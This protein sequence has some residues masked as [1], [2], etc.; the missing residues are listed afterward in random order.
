MQKF[1][2]FSQVYAPGPDSRVVCCFKHGL[3]AGYVSEGPDCVGDR[4]KTKHVGSIWQNRCSD[5]TNFL[6]ECSLWSHIGI[7]ELCDYVRA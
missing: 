7:V 3:S 2:N 6:C 1:G 5:F 4:K